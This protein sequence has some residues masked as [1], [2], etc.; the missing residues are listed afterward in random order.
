MA[1]DTAAGGPVLAP[2]AAPFSQ[3]SRVVQA[4]LN[5]VAESGGANIEL[6]SGEVPCAI[7]AIVAD[8]H[9]HETYFQLSV[10]LWLMCAVD[11]LLAIVNFGL[12]AAA[13]NRLHN[14]LRFCF[15][16]ALCRSLVT[17]VVMQFAPIASMTSLTMILFNVILAIGA[18]GSAFFLWIFASE[19]ISECVLE[20]LLG[21]SC[22]VHAVLAGA[23]HSQL[24]TILGGRTR[25]FVTVT[26][27]RHQKLI[28]RMA[29]DAQ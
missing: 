1:V 21:V 28:D 11:I 19:S 22:F 6:A 12:H 29:V 27:E 10:A 18:C 24:N 9:I 14:F 13:L 2:T 5:A 16:L 26:D 4:V 17:P 8:R 15:T 25:T 20:T 7:P 23:I 3:D